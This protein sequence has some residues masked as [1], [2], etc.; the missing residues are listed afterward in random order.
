MDI[1]VDACCIWAESFIRRRFTPPREETPYPISEPSGLRLVKDL[2]A[3]CDKGNVPTQED[4]GRIGRISKDLLLSMRQY[5]I[6][7]KNEEELAQRAKQSLT[8]APVRG[9]NTQDGFD[10]GIFDLEDWQ[11]A[12]DQP[13]QGNALAA[14]ETKLQLN[15]HA[16]RTD[17]K[18]MQMSRVIP[19][20][21]ASGTGKSRLSEE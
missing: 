9:M 13:F 16:I 19:V 3:D 12:W 5:L 10:G 7:L 8:L 14:L 1:L 2:L 20:V 17:H 11:R 6:D 18:K 21:Q 4:D 15:A